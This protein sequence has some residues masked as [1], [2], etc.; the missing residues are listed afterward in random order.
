MEYFAYY[1]ILSICGL[2]NFSVQH[3]SNLKENK[4]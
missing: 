4:I 2:E 3:N 1:L